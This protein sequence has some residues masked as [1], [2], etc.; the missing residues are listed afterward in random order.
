MHGKCVLIVDDHPTVRGMIRSRFESEGFEL[1]DAAN[2]AEAVN[3]AQEVKPDLVILDLAMPVMNGL[4]AARI[5][6]RLAPE[7]PLLMFTNTGGSGLEQEARSSGIS[8]VFSKSDGAEAVLVHVNKIL[9]LIP[10]SPAS[11]GLLSRQILSK[12][13]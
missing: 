3:K 11:W 4:E 9:N 2:G 1:C 13:Y 5:L 8:A 12:L 6:K 10:E 7:V